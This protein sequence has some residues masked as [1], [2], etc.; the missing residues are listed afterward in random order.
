[1]SALLCCGSCF[2]THNL[3]E[4]GNIYLWLDMLLLSA[5]DKVKLYSKEFIFKSIID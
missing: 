5:D 3:S 4:D 2:D 1:M